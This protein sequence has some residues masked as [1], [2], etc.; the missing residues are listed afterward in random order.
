MSETEMRTPCSRCGSKNTHAAKETLMERLVSYFL[1]RQ[2]LRCGRCGWTG[3]V[4]PVAKRRRRR[5]GH[6]RPRP[7]SDVVEADEVDLTAIDQ[8]FA[9]AK[10]P[11][12]KA[13]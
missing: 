3:R 11:R 12:R 7:S 10:P 6:H 1:R 5:S 2:T 4:G 13:T 8:A 9:D